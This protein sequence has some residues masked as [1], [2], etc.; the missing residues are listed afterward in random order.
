MAQSGDTGEHSVRSLAEI[1]QEHGLE[2]EL[3]TRPGR[4]RRDNEPKAD[5]PARPAPEDQP[6]SKLRPPGDPSPRTTPPRSTPSQSAAPYAEIL[7]EHGLESEFGT[8]PDRRRDGDRRA[9][10][11]ARPA[12]EDQPPS[13]LKPAPEA[14]V[15]REAS[16]PAGA[17]PPAPAGDLS[18]RTTPP[19]NTPG[20]E[21][22]AR[23][24]PPRSPGIASTAA[25][26]TP[27]APAPRTPV[28]PDVP[29]HGRRSTDASLPPGL[30]PGAMP[31]PSG[32]STAAIPALQG[33][34]S[35]G[36]SGGADDLDVGGDGAPA[37]SGPAGIL[38]WARFAGELVLA[39]GAGIGIYFAFTVLWELLPY[40]AVVAAPLTVTALV[41]GVSAWRHRRGQS[42][43]GV[44]LLAV[45][46]FAATLLV[47]APAAALL[48]AG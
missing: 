36:A 37:P 25:A 5:W 39:V 8:R 34:R 9:G 19:R 12:P 6:R 32:P 26:A 23:T 35:R 27:V 14:A 16:M 2:T 24:P 44:P 18:G 45:L 15:S 33:S 41:A 48:A 1:L 20:R 28:S 38:A 3:G 4:R 46:L 42:A 47:I 13:R 17:G 11:P 31:G 40:V 21:V 10:W 30:V 43:L 22:P 7:R 29:V